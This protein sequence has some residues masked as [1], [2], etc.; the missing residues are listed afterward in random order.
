MATGL[1]NAPISR[2]DVIDFTSTATGSIDV[3]LFTLAA[4]EFAQVYIYE[5]HNGSSGSLDLTIKNAFTNDID[6]YSVS[7]FSTGIESDGALAS[8]ETP[9]VPSTLVGN[10]PGGSVLMPK[11]SQLNAI[12]SGGSNTGTRIFMQL[13]AYNAPN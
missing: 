8:G 7:S 2:V 10:L 12:W 1:L 5:V 9:P 3:A 6:I 4:N 13:I 11:G